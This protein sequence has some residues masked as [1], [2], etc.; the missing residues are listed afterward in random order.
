MFLVS[1]LGNP[2]TEYDNTRHNVGFSVIDELAKRNGATIK[3]SK[4][5]V[6]GWFQFLLDDEKIVGAKPL[7]FMN[8]SG[9]VSY[10]HLRAHET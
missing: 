2:G 4:K 9:P 7:T 1:G 5:F 8:E 6:A 10:T 3:E